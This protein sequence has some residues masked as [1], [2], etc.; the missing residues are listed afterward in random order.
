LLRSPALW[1]VCGSLAAVALLWLYLPPGAGVDSAAHA[2]KV[3]VVRAGVT[4]LWDG[5][6]YSGSYGAA[7]YG[8]LYYLV[9]SRTGE[10]A[11]VITAAGLLPVLFW[12]YLRGVWRCGSTQSLPAAI[13]LAVT[14]LLILPF[15]MHPFL[16]ALA[17]AMAG[18]ALLG[19]KGSLF[20]V[21]GAALTGLALFV[22][23]LGA[24]CV[25]AFLVADLVGRPYVRPRLVVF[26]AALAPFVAVRLAM[27]VVFVQPAVEI[28]L[29]GSQLKYVAIGVAGAALVLL[30]RDPDRR[31]K[32]LVFAAAA[33]ACAL[34]YLV[35]H[36]PVGDDMGRFYALFAVPIVLSVRR[37]YLPLRLLAL[38]AVALLVLPLTMAAAVIGG[39]GPSFSDWQTFFSPGL[40]LARRYHDPDYRLAVVPLSKHWDSY[41]FP[42]AGYPLAQ[43]WYRQSDAV[44]DLVLRDGANVDAERYAAWL[45]S[46]GVEYVFWGHAALAPDAVGI[47]A[48]LTDST[49]FQRVADAGRWTVY[50][51]RD[52]Q[53]LVVRT[54]PGSTGAAVTRY[55]RTSL[56]LTVF[57]P[58]DYLVKTTWSPYWSLSR[59]RGSLSR[60][61]GDWV[62]LHAAAGGTYG[63]RFTSSLADVLRQLR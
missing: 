22:N 7:T 45:R 25:V 21:L 26:A 56:T 63:L 55:E 44:H 6:W 4:S 14:V 34:A 3:A 11:L 10:S 19:A 49:E 13:G 29:L 36:N 20:W 32:A 30:S 5:L 38:G 23:P 18:A 47:P 33:G 1:L 62:D 53:P 58:G 43:G 41:F 46:V 17:L 48:L 27:M 50:R 42:L 37:L 31:A 54:S 8:Y 2:Y 12:C 40:R 39:T 24:V 52:P 51:L 9:A 57:G 28:D 61:P 16:V 59:G 60:A 15:G 35:P